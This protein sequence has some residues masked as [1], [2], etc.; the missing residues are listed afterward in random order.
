ME[1]LTLRFVLAM[2]IL[3]SIRLIDG[4]TK[5]TMYEGVTMEVKYPTEEYP[6]FIYHS[7]KCA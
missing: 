5:T 2:K 7:M 6:T 3:G 4:V 1:L